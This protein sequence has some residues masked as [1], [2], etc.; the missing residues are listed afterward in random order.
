MSR[1]SLGK[2]PT[3][4]SSIADLDVERLTVS[5]AINTGTSTA[6]DFSTALP[7]G[8]GGTSATTQSGARSA[9]GLTIGTEVQAYDAGLASI[10][11]LT[12]SANKMI[13]TTASDTYTT[14]DLTSFARNLLDDTD[15]TTMRST[16]GLGSMAT[17][18]SNSVNITGGTI[19]LSDPVSSSQVATKNYVDSLV[20]G[21]AIKQPVRCATQQL[22]HLLTFILMHLL[23]VLSLLRSTGF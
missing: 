19:S 7:I 2:K 3:N 15:A 22:T 11:G 14:T 10:A 20:A 18:N 1:F 12:T 13:Y 8:Q 6:F 21:L 4:G 23:M 9:L 5:T 16:L 17:Q